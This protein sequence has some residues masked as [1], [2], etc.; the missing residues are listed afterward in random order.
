MS[1]GKMAKVGVGQRF[2]REVIARDLLHPITNK[3]KT[4]VIDPEGLRNFQ[5]M[6][7]QG[8]GGVLISNHFSALDPFW[9]IAEATK[10]M[11]L[12]SIEVMQPIR[13]DRVPPGLMQF[14]NL[15]G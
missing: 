9:V 6:L 3:H 4:E 14:A 8:K 13:W 2:F 7:R 12:R 5:E 1:E 10:T 15:S 11:G